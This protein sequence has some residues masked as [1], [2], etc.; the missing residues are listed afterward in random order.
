MKETW[1]RPLGQEDSLGEENGNPLRYSCLNNPV[2]GGA[3]QATVHRGA[4]NQTRL[5]DFTFHFIY[6]RPE[7]D[8][9]VRKFPWRRK[10]QPTPLCMDRGAWWVIVH[11]VTELDTTE[12]LTHTHTHPYVYTY[13]SKI[14]LLHLINTHTHTHILL[15]HLIKAWE[16]TFAKERERNQKTWTKLNGITEYEIKKRN[17]LD[18]SKKSSYS[19]V[20]F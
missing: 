1:V 9:W 16:R 17:K 15:L 13:T 8:P 10:W 3:W 2:S 14:F 5:R 7:F 12:Q 20:G 4:K 11:R 6:R 19:P 18:K